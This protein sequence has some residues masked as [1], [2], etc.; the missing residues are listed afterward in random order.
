MFG[1]VSEGHP[2]PLQNNIGIVDNIYLN[3]GVD[4]YESQ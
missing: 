3:P 2:A 1:I 4:M